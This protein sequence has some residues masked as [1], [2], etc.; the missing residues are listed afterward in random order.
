[1]GSYR[2]PT[3][4]MR[5]VIDQLCRVEAALGGVPPFDELGLGSE[6][7]STLLEESAR[8]SVTPNRLPAAK[9]R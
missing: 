6:L 3:E 4:D 2:A 8:G 9:A 7:S 1:M 5:F